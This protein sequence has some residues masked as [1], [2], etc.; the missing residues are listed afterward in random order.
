MPRI[1]TALRISPEERARWAAAADFLGISRA[2]FIRLATNEKA[3]KVERERRL[4]RLEAEKP[5][6]KKGKP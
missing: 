5:K 2:S 4:S 3:A 6:G 1:N